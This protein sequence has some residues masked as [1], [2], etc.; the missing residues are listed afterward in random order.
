M[1]TKGSTHFDFEIPVKC[2]CLYDF[3]R[4]PFPREMIINS[5]KGAVPLYFNS[6]LKYLLKFIFAFR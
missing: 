4:E 1:S 3:A 6:S 2:S 5:C